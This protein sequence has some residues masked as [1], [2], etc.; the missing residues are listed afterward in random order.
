MKKIL[1]FIGLVLLSLCTLQAQDLLTKQR[2][3]PCLNKTFTIFMH[4]TV[5]EAGETN[6]DEENLYTML[7][8]LNADF[9]PICVQFEI[10][11]IDTIKNYQYDEMSTAEW[12]EAQVIYHQQNRINVFVLSEYENSANCGF[13]DLG[14]IANNQNNG[15]ILLKE[16]CLLATTRS[17]SH[18]MGRYFGLQYTFQPDEPSNSSA[19][20]V[21]GS[22]GETTGDGIVDT[23]ADPYIDGEDP[24]T[25]V[26][27]NLDCRFINEKQDAN[28]EFYQPDV[29]NIMSYYP[30]ECKCGFTLGQYLKMAETCKNATGMW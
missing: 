28:G 1:L 27:V 6:V 10:C 30:D 8:T 24:A 15:I 16:N 23:P 12:Q 19:E 4:V 18:Q 20:L 29:G 14:E 5:N 9:A 26:N 2:E 21:D 3:L 17:L 13:A 11:Q 7:D 25:Y 22:N